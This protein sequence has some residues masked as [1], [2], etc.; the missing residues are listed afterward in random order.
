MN[1]CVIV[2]SQGVKQS[3]CCSFIYSWKLTIVA[4]AMHSFRDGDR[5]PGVTV[6]V[7]DAF[8]EKHQMRGLD[9][10]FAPC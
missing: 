6:S 1:D 7:L 4:N 2:S 10:K 9:I 8:L 5:G 3:V